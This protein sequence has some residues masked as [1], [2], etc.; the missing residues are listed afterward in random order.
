ME[1]SL[2]FGFACPRC[3]HVVGPI[4]LPQSILEEISRS[5]VEKRA[6]AAMPVQFVACPSCGQ[7]SAGRQLDFDLLTSRTQGQPTNPRTLAIRA[8]IACATEKC[9]AQIVIHTTA[10]AG[11]SDSTMRARAA[12]WEFQEGLVCPHC[13]RF[14]Q[15][16]LA[17]HYWFDGLGPSAGPGPSVN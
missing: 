15:D 2:Q 13:R 16:C 5:Q 7:V 3:S 8:H 14:L 17:G 6:I 4:A 12:E 11:T 9:E 1:L 10:N